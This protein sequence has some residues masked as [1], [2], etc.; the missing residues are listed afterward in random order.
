[1]TGL[2]GCLDSMWNGSKLKPLEPSSV[3][4]D[5]RSSRSLVPDTVPRTGLVTAGPFDTGREGDKPVDTFLLP[6]TRELVDRG[7]QR[8]NIYC[9]PC[10]GRTGDGDGMI[11]QRGFPKPPTYHSDRLRR[12][13]AGHF[14]DVMT[15]G[16]GVMYSYSDRVAVPDRWA[17]AAYIRVLQRS[18]DARIDDVPA[19]RRARL[20]GGAK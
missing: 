17:I 7:Q 3:F 4:A 2:P 19:D 13:P 9:S 20:E 14:F 15:H 11:V 18:R 1:M 6:V 16:Y 8:F 10:H 12:A 5:A